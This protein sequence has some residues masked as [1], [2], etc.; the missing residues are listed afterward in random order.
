MLL[1]YCVVNTN[2][3]DYLGACL[4]AIERTHP[5]GLER[6]VLVLDNASEDGSAEAVRAR[7]GDIRLIARR[8]RANK[9]ENDSAVLREA[10]G[11]Y[12][13]LL[14]E[15]SEL[16]P[17]AA[18]ALVQALEDDD[19]AAVAVAQLLDPGGRAR[20]CAW[21]LPSI[22]TAL[23][24]AL[25]LHRLFTVQSRG[26]RVRAVEWGQSSAMLVRRGAAREI[27]YLDADFFYSEEPDF[28]KRLGDAGWR[29]LYVPGA[30]AV[31][32]GQLGGPLQ[33]AR[34]RIVEFHRGRDWH[35]RKHHGRLAAAIF[36][37][38]AAWPYLLRALAAL[39]LP[40]HEPRRYLLHARQALLPTR[41]QGIREA[42]GEHN[43][44][45]DS[46]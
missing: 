15:D 33:A 19:S 40:G 45:L 2:G 34:R 24:G 23:I 3:R 13:L 36:R 10:N 25:F 27:D 44:R 5:E 7:G 39:V 9:A 28:C 20:P 16:L 32:H 11:E 35:M 22:R 17:G 30:R 31:H 43:R 26:D 4:D 38:L 1:S 37:P 8:H 41:G 14:N 18:E 42:I 46:L 12:C 6:E 21:R 29:T